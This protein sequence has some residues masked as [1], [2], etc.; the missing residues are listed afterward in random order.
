MAD[1]DTYTSLIRG[2]LYIAG[3]WRPGRG[4]RLP[5]H[6]KY[7]QT[8]LGEVSLADGA[9]MEAAIAASVRGFETYRIWPAGRRQAV[10][11]TLAERLEAQQEA[12]AQLICAE[13][14]KPIGYARG[15][16][17]RGLL[18]LRTAA[19][20]A[21]RMAGEVVNIDYG[22]GIGRTAFT[23]RVPVGPVAAISPFNFP[24]NL[25]LHKLAPALA[26]GNSILLKPSP[27][28]PLT[29]LALAGLLA[30]T[31]LPAGAVQVILAKNAVAE[32]MV[33]DPRL[34]MLSFTGSPA[35]GWH[36]KELSGRKRVALELGGNAAVLID[37]DTDL[38]AAARRVAVGAYLYAGQICISTQ[39]IFVVE[40][41]R[42]RFEALLLREIEALS[43]GDPADAT[44]TVGP[45]ID[46]QHLRRVSDWV[47]E[48]TA[49][50]ARCLA[51]GAL[52]SERRRLYAPTLLTDTRTGMK[53]RDEEIFGPV[54]VLESVPDFAAGLAAIN[55]SRFG[56]QAGVFTGR[57]A[58]IQQAHARL[59][60]GAVII[61]D[62]PGFRVD[63]MPYGGVKDSGLGR[64]GLRYA[65]AEMTEPRLLVY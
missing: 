37:D 63:P 57:L 17:T 36:L 11:E 32:A 60:V 14:G 13:A 45:L 43:V 21:V 62:V 48:A 35:V 39:R 52:L 16:V 64:E 40:A 58:H 28:A 61:N 51:G 25:A 41:V 20:E 49:E 30:D 50:G 5:V 23:R 19:A 3:Q 24:L 6:D 33:R 55:D 34:R 56:L 44:T 54:A 27:Y 26:V 42:D 53:V 65:M 22:V 12:F 8:L 15:E 4:G 10:L 18:T 9:D 29:A 31:D 59:E 46:L 38:P 2:E 7:H 47:Q 1:S